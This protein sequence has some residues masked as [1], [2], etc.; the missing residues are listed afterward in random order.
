MDR[1]NARILATAA[2]LALA[3]A[4]GKSESEPKSPEPAM[5]KNAAADAFAELGEADAKLAEAQA[6][7]P[8][9][10]KKLGSMG[11]PIKVMVGDKAVFLCCGNCKSRLLAEPDKYLAKLK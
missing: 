11:T 3:V 9:S 6:I 10:G 1:W 4:C 2:L 7:C 5:D 8:V